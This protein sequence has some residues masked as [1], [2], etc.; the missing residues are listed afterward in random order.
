MKKNTVIEL[1]KDII[2]TGLDLAVFLISIDSGF[3]KLG[4]VCAIYIAVRYLAPDSR[5][6]MRSI[7]ICQEK[8]Q[9]WWSDRKEQ[10]EMFDDAEEMETA[11]E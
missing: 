1:M 5:G 8:V 4:L 9:Q 3:T 6:L 10:K 7:E 11:D 2:V